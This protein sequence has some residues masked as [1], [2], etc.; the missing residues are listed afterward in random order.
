MIDRGISPRYAKALFDLSRADNTLE[1]KLNDF[2]LTIKVF[3]ENLKL[4]KLI[5][6]PQLSLDDKKKVLNDTLKLNPAFMNFLFFLIEKG[7]LANLKQIAREYR[8]MV[9]KFLK[10]WEADIVTAVPI[11]DESESRLK[12]KLEETFHK[13]VKINKKLNPKMIGGAILIMGNEMLDWSVLGRLRKLK[14]N[15]IA[16]RV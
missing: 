16:T 11:D 15:L 4:V 14:D 6:S 13:R 1:E 9:N 3:K 12:H 10:I 5:K 2:D 7:R 8:L